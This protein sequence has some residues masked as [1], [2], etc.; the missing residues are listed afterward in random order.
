MERNPKVGDLNG[1]WS[2]LM[3]ILLVTYPPLLVALITWGSWVTSNI[4]HLQGEVTI[5]RERTVSVVEHRADL[6]MEACMTNIRADLAK[7]QKE[8]TEIPSH[9]PPAWW[10]KYVRE[11][12]GEHHARLSVLEQRPTSLKNTP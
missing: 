7:L 12:L 9:L 2:V 3:R 11:A 4:F 1:H 8:I 5:G 6:K 10:E